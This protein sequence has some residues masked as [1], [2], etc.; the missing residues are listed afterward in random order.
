MI[1][2]VA[3]GNPDGEGEDWSP[4]RVVERYTYDPYGKV[5][6]ESWTPYASNPNDGA[7]VVSAESNSGMAF[8]PLGNPWMWTGQRYDSA[9]GLYAFWARTYSPTLGRWLQRDPR[10]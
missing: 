1:G 4:P 9:V 3:S 10:G 7:Y 2:L 5:F 6:I 8:S